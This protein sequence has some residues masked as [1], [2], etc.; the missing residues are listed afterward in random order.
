MGD[1][2]E[3]AKISVLEPG[4]FKGKDIV[5]K[6]CYNITRQEAKRFRE[7][8]KE[9]FPEARQVLILGPEVDMELP[10]DG[11]LVAA[12]PLEHFGSM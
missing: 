9:A 2:S 10:C 8:M 11:T 12:V 4:A 3:D 5:I 7:S 6:V 1:I